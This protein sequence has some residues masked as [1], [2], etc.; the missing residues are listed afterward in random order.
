M[1][2]TAKASVVVNAL[3]ALS[4][5][6]GSKGLKTEGTDSDEPWG[7]KGAELPADEE[8]KSDNLEKLIDVGTLPD[9]LKREAWHM[10]RKRVSTFGFNGRLGSYPARV[11]IRT[12]DGQRPIAV[13]MYGASPEK[14][15]I[16]E[17]QLDTWF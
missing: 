17:K 12:Q 10:L 2:H 8:Y 3:H 4:S 6:T 15:L 11:H 5:P 1:R 14:R 9:H 16:I 13:P 7:P